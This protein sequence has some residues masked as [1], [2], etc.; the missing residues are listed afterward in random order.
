MEFECIAA[1]KDGLLDGKT[2][3]ESD[4]STM[5]VSLSASF[6]RKKK[7]EERGACL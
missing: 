3:P 2:G 7:G 1:E 4:F 6:R 5:L